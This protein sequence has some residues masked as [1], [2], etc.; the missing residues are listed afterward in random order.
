MPRATTN[1]LYRTFVRGLITEAS[2][3]T[4]PEDSSFD[5]LNTVP[6][7]K[8]NR[9][10][11]LGMQYSSADVESSVIVAD[12]DNAYNEFV[13]KAVG[14]KSSTNFLVVQVAST[15]YFFDMN[16][17][18]IE[19]GKKTFSIN[20]DTYLRPGASTAQIDTEACQFAA[21]KGFLFIVS[22][23]IEPL[24]VEYDSDADTITVTS[25]AILIRDF[26]GLDDGLQNDEEPTTLSKEHHYNLQNQGWVGT[27]RSASTFGSV[28]LNGYTYSDQIY[29][30]GPFGYVPFGAFQL[31]TADSPIFKFYSELF[32]Y[33]GN[34][35]Q[36]WAARAEA[37]D[38]AKGIKQ[39]D[40]LP[41]VLDKLFSGSN[42]APRG[43]Y[44]LN[45]FKKDRSSVS[46]ISGITTEELNLRPNSITFFSGRSWYAGASTVY[47]SQLLD[48]TSSN[49]AGLCYQEADPTSEDISELIATD[50]GVV[51][52]PEADKIVRLL[53]LGNGVMVFAQNGVWFIS[54]GD[55]AFSATNIAVDK[56][57][58][59]GTKSP[60]S[61]VEADNTIFWW[62]ETG[63]QALQQSQGQFGPIPGKFGNTNISEQTIQ[64]FWNE[65]P[66]EALPYVKTVHDT[67]N[68][69]ILWL[70]RDN[71]DV[72]GNYEYNKVLLY[73][74]TLQAFYPWKFSSIT[75]GPVVKGMF[76]NVGFA[77]TV[78]V[79]PVTA[80]GVAVTAATVAVT[81]GVD[82]TS[83]RPSNIKYTVH[84]PS[85][86]F[87]IGEVADSNFVDW[88]AFNTVGATYESYIETGYEIHA[89]A[90]RK[91][92]ITYLF[93]HFNQVDGATCTCQTKWDWSNQAF[94]N[95]WSTPFEAYRERNRPSPTTAEIVDG[96][97]VVTTKNKVRGSGKSVQIRFGT[98]TAGKNFDILGWSVAVSGNSQP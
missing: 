55:A 53:P 76:L 37:D 71:V 4:Y 38:D 41:K 46:G 31:S 91:K 57:S 45:A 47:F 23:K 16:V 68:N 78:D 81:V 10:R 33:P 60:L 24:S 85:Q 9:T 98:S 20:L 95:K 66:E 92:Q 3:L 59:V 35:K 43:H 74:L 39:G 84:I 40:F 5:E 75:N 82:I 56:V 90:M 6:S 19:S 77:S 61:I 88:K 26:E 50:G 80:G 14:G 42:R 11:R 87:T 34:N 69:I 32:R 28:S 64:T 15:V 48:S 67:R 30:T 7:R 2:P 93:V 86:G 12:K 97:D 58:S 89:D 83:V 96:F 51:T 52:I 21:G 22:D 44:I 1:K 18:P 72:T 13:W 62:S 65:I 27:T 49:K 8:G 29:F 70:Y 17:T 63:I 73:D 25:I 79:E 54:G 36:W 94:S